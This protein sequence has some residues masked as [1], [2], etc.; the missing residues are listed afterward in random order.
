[1]LLSSPAGNDLPYDEKLVEQGRNFCNKIWNAF[2]LVQGWQ[3][4]Q[5][6]SQPAEN[7]TA[8]LW[9]ESRLNETITEVNDLYDKYR[10][11]EALMTTYKLIWDDFCAWYLELIKPAYLAPIDPVTYSATT[12]FFEKVLT[13]IHPFTPFISE[14]LWQ[15]LKPRTKEEALIVH[16]WPLIGESDSRIIKSAEL[17][18][19]IINQIRALRNSK[20][21]SPKESLALF[22]KTQDQEPYHLF[23]NLI[24]KLGNLSAF[25]TVGLPQDISQGVQFIVKSEECFIPLEG[26]TDPETERANLTK[27]LEYT[28]GFM[29]SVTNKLSNEKFVANAKADVVDRE[30]QKLADAEGKLRAIEQALASLN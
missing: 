18:F 11:S 30:R 21:L 23:G 26:L 7:A 6:L 20:G 28:K 19:E 24:I 8:I 22:V 9:F 10:I 3:V 27:E 5:S 29:L 2:R 14:A 16:A 17:A 1:M 15:A 12:N 4:D 25:S 13:L